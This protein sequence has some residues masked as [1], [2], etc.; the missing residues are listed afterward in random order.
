MGVMWRPKVGYNNGPLGLVAKRLREE[1][2][3]I[4]QEALPERW[5]D[6]IL[7]LDERERQRGDAG[8]DGKSKK[9]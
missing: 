9:S 5:V 3:T 2:Q 6:L 1:G 8:K 7:F 4:K